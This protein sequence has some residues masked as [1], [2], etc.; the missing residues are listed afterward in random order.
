MLFNPEKMVFETS[1]DVVDY[2][3][4]GFVPSRKNFEKV[5][6]KVRI[7]DDEKVEGQV[8]IPSNL[9]IDCD[10][11]TMNYA[12]NRVYENRVKNRNI[13]LAMVGIVLAGVLFGKVSGKKKEKE[14]DNDIDDI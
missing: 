13:T 11:D 14:K 1:Y 12:L 4:K 7:P 3:S 9:F 2:V 10:I 6:S 8:Y 5:M